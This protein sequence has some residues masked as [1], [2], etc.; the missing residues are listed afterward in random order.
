MGG[1]G[2]SSVGCVGGEPRFRED[3]AVNVSARTAHT[4]L[5]FATPPISIHLEAVVA[6]TD[7]AVPRHNTAVLTPQ[8]VARRQEL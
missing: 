1:S 2:G 4:Q 6:E 5:T 7:R 8:L 3:G